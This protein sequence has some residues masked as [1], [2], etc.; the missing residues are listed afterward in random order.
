[1]A[2]DP[3]TNKITMWFIVSFLVLVVA[4][5]IIAGA[6]SSGSPSGSG[7]TPPA[8][9]VATVAPAI[10][11]TD[12]TVGNSTSSV[13]FIEYGDYECPACGE[14][15]P[16]IE[17]LI[18][19]YGTR[20]LFVFRNFP[21]YTIH[22]DAGISAQAAE[23]AGMEGGAT[24]FW[25]MHNMLY[26]KQNDWVTT[27]P[28]QVVSKYFNGY[29]I[30]IGLNV[31]TFDADIN[32][33]QVMNKISTDVAG[34]NAA[35]IDHTPTFFLNLKQIPNP[36]TYAQFAAVLDAALASSTAATTAAH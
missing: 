22:P 35:G 8:G 18:S 30:A 36:S 7:V 15:E 32:S 33:T 2:T 27:D 4:G 11:N 23:A 14:Y 19:N 13:S 25:E 5:V 17:Q 31:A 26:A 16:V 29:A 3:G 10:S 20:V 6:Y 1:M 24:A 21:L 12:W 34:G 9:F 28:S